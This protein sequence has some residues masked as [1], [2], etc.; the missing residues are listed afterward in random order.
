[1]GNLCGN[2][3]I[4]KSFGRAGNTNGPSDIGPMG[5]PSKSSSGCNIGG[6]I[7]I[8]STDTL[9]KSGST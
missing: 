7:D 9:S 8:Q 3:K 4:W 5:V 6:P 2:I 1:M